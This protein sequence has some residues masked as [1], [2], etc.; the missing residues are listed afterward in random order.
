MY[1]A[2]NQEYE[3]I[4]LARAVEQPW[5]SIRKVWIASHQAWASDI[6]C[7]ICG[8]AEPCP[9][10]WVIETFS[11]E[12]IHLKV[13]VRSWYVYSPF[14]DSPKEIGKETRKF[15]KSKFPYFQ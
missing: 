5:V 8:N 11:T 2:M 7:N 3:N 14:L 12:H 1:K 10:A 9:D 6:Y 4:V 13:D 15:L